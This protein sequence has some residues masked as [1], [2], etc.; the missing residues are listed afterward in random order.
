MWSRGCVLG[1]PDGGVVAAAFGVFEPGLIGQLYNAARA[2]CG[3]ADI[4]AAREAGAVTALR[5]V[6]GGTVLGAPERAAEVT[7]A[8]R[9]AVE[10][11]DTAGPCPPGWPG[12][13]GPP[14]SWASS[15]TPA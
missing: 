12:C 13:P 7:G 6:L 11:M 15:G 3:L 8:L 10:A 9:R 5:T 1:E 14:M 2:A 4:R